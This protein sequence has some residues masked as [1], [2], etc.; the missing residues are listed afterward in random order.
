MAASDKLE[1]LR[2]AV[3]SDPENGGLRLVYADALTKSERLAEATVE[4]QAL[5]VADALPDAEIATAG[6]VAIAAGAYAFATS[7]AGR[8]RELGAV[9]TAAHLQIQVDEALERSNAQY[10]NPNSAEPNLEIDQTEKTTFADVGGLRDVKTAIER[11]IILPFREAALYERYGRTAG[12]SLLLYG[13]P[14]C[15]KTL[16]AR[17][18]AGEC[19]LPFLNVRI[20]AIMNPYFGVSERNLHL[21]FVHA[22]AMAPC[23][24]FIDELDAIGFARRKSG[25]GPGRALVDQLLQELDAIGADNNGLLILAA[26]NVPWD[27]DEALKR[28]GRF[29]RSILVTPPDPDAREAVLTAMLRG[30]PL[31][32]VD[33][34]A[35]AEKAKLLSGADLLA[36]VERA[37]D[38]AIDHAV[39]TGSE[40]PLTQR[41]FEA[42]IDLVIPST[43]EWIATARR[44]VEFANDSGRYNDVRDFL[45]TGEAKSRKAK[46]R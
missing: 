24:M 43:L 8:A 16:L 15:G 33:V 4:Y 21:A 22:R 40:R 37:T 12:G 2:G 19:G 23:V 27:V 6:Q 26:T 10:P 13:P 17:A 41:D 42:A 28:P 14:G 46:T 30:R 44:Y 34:R 7:L 32:G 1:P 3:A 35:V 36:V 20:E 29:D 25:G 45:Q 5:F 39:S 38:A 31:Q 9:S 11:M 18:T